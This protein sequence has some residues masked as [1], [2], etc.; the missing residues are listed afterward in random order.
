MLNILAWEHLSGFLH[1]VVP[2]LLYRERYALW[3]N[4]G[5]STILKTKLERDFA[6][7]L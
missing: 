4:K 2:Y 1:D 3:L 6:T 7:Q 5:V